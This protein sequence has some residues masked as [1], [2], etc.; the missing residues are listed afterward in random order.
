MSNWVHF[1]NPTR[2]VSCLRLTPYF[3]QHDVALFRPYFTTLRDIFLPPGLRGHSFAASPVPTLDWASKSAIDHQTITEGLPVLY[4]NSPICG[5]LP[6]AHLLLTR[7]PPQL[8]A[9]VRHRPGPFPYATC[10]VSHP[11]IPRSTESKGRFYSQDLVYS[12][13]GAAA[14]PV[15]GLTG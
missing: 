9:F 12:L 13:T 5:Q 7:P 8:P 14:V 1:V 3:T 2:R 4:R 11:S 10:C 15:A 6:H